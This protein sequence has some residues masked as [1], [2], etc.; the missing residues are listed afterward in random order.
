MFA[1]KTVAMGHTVDT[2]GADDA[3]T[4]DSTAV[5]TVVIAMELITARIELGLV[6]HRVR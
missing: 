3:L 1:A 4:L 5:A 6:T 2:A